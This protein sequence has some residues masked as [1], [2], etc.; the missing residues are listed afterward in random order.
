[1]AE[2]TTRRIPCDDCERR[3][4]EIEE[5]GICEVISCEEDPDRPGECLLIF[6]PIDPAPE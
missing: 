1:M 2:T 3:S 6:R 4:R 5:D